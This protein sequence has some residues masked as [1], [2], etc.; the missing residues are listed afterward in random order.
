MPTTARIMMLAAALSLVGCEDPADVN[1]PPPVTEKADAKSRLDNPPPTKPDSADPATPIKPTVKHTPPPADWSIQMIDAE[2]LAKLRQETAADG[3]V[4][5]IDYW[6]TWCGSCRAMFP[7]LHAAM[8]ERGD[9][10]R[11]ISISI[12]QDSKPEDNYI[13]RAQT[14]VID[15]HAWQDAYVAMPGKES[16]G[17]IALATNADWAGVAVPAVFVYGLNGEQ[18]YEMTTPS[19]TPDQ[20]VAKIAESVDQA[21]AKEALAE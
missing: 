10:V 5:I 20:W 19:G 14:Y 8:A 17:A 6:A 9:K 15:Q 18:A 13:D 12:D 4:L 21:S 2:G 3:K 11:L 7:K 1:V 16:R